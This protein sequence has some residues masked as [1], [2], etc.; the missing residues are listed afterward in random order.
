MAV[1]NRFQTLLRNKR[2][3]EDREI[4][5]EDIAEEINISRDTLSRYAN[6]RIKRYD[7]ATVEALCRYF[8]VEVGDFLYLEPGI[9][10]DKIRQAEAQP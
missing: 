8:G 3:K 1:L 10:L 6:Q 4:K 7:S 9:E 2:A 5:I